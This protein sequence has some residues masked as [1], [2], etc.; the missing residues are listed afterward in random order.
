MEQRVGRVARLGS[1]HGTIKV[2]QLR[3]PASADTVLRGQ[4]IVERK[5]EKAR[6]LV[7]ANGV[8]PF[9]VSSGDESQTSSV[10]SR[11]EQLRALLGGWTSTTADRQTTG[12]IPVAA[13]AA[14]QAG[15][16]AAGKIGQTSILLSCMAGRVSVSLDAQIAAC[17]LALEGS[18]VPVDHSDYSSACASIQAWA[19]HVEASES[20]GAIVAMP[21][22]RRKLLN[23]IDSVLQN[24]PPHLRPAR[25]RLVA[26]AREVAS[27]THGAAVE[28]E[29]AGLADSDL[30]EDEWLR[31]VAGTSTT[32]QRAAIMHRHTFELHALLLF[33]A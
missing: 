31:E 25:A 19:E 26:A 6:A 33:K 14:G 28:Q 1:A 21:Q 24:T 15:F 30:G 8:R 20:A 16:L 10:P 9:S 17:Q 29:L 12:T 7:G 27:A 13:L 22:Q 5:W 23:R 3:P 32:N 18:P 11:A 4:L 2:Y